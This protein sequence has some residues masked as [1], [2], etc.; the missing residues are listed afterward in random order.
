[1]GAIDTWLGKEKDGN[2]EEKEMRRKKAVAALLVFML[3]SLKIA[4]EREK[5]CLMEEIYFGYKVVI[6][7][8]SN[9]RYIFFTQ[10]LKE[11]W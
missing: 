8:K 1:M 5:N 11:I 6:V 7:Q 10:Q 2:S 3:S 4:F 9:H